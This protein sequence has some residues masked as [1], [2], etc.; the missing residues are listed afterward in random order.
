MDEQKLI[1]DCKHGNAKA[2]RKLY[3]LYAP[4]MMGVSMRYVKDYDD[5]CDV[6]QD[7][8]VKLFTKIDSY[9]GIGSFEGWARRI[10][11]TTALEFLRERH[12]LKFALNI[13]D[14]NDSTG[15]FNNT[16]IEEIAADELMNV[17]LG[18]PD[19]YRTVFNLFAIEGFS[20]A[21]IAKAL[22][23]SE[24]TSRSQF[25]RARKLLQKK[26]QDIY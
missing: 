13:D 25:A 24:G 20:H 15:G 12:A 21:E 18:L 7:G 22:E 17:I 9:L 26:L 8:F 10:F 5:A 3:D 23:I 16:I 19:G 1:A 2:Q 4:V 11:V 14:L 6:L